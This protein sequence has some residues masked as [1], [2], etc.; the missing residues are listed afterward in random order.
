MLLKTLLNSVEK[1]K[2]F[3]YEKIKLV[4]VGRHKQI[5]VRVRPKKR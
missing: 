1:H 5:H 4:T 3:L 2:G